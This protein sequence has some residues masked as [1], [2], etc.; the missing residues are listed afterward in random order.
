MKTNPVIVKATV[1]AKQAVGRAE[2]ELIRRHEAAAKQID[3]W[4]VARELRP[5]TP[6]LAAEAVRSACDWEAP[7][8][9]AMAQQ[10]G[11]DPL[12]G[13]RTATHPMAVPISRE[14]ATR[15]RPHLHDPR[16]LPAYRSQLFYGA[17]N[18]AL[19]AAGVALA[20]WLA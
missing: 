7:V 14:M 17:L 5:H 1:S 4:D 19:I 10:A 20:W 3:R 11:P 13:P 12:T 15:V 6:R 8:I 9:Q 16:P 18:L 2:R